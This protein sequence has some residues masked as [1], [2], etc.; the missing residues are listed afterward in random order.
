[1]LQKQQAQA[2]VDAKKILTQG[3]VDVFEGVCT[4]LQNKGK[5]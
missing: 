4:S 1:M 3:L 5:I 2:A